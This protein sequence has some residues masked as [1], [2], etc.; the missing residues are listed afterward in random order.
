MKFIFKS[1]LFIPIALTACQTNSNDD[2]VTYDIT[3][4]MPEANITEAKQSPTTT[5]SRLT[6]TDADKD[7]EPYRMG[8]KH[9]KHLHEQC[10]TTEEVRD[11]LLDINARTTNIQ[12]HIGAE[13]ANSYL[14]GI[15]DYLTEVSDTLATTLF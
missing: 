2:S 6:G 9:A 5:S 12:F 8:R 1:T 10:R 13:A 15:K 3:A 14:Q 11:E 7:S 4:E